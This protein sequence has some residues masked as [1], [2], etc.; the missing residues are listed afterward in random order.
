[1]G[2]LALGVILLIIGIVCKLFASV[3]HITDKT[4]KAMGWI[5]LN[6]IVAIIG[7]FCMIFGGLMIFMNLV[8]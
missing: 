3:G 6:K 4:A 8:I 2:S 7:W 1:M 5:A